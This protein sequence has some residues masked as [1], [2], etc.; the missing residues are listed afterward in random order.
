MCACMC[1]HS[2]EE[3]LDGMSYESKKGIITLDEYYWDHGRGKLIDH[4][5]NRET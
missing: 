3:K 1:T 5:L 4:G 2:H